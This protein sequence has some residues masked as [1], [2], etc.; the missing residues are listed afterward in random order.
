M[1][2][3]L[4]FRT[5]THMYSTYLLLCAAVQCNAMSVRTY[6][7]VTICRRARA[8]VVYDV[9][10][11]AAWEGGTASLRRPR[12]ACIH[13]RHMDAFVIATYTCTLCYYIE[14]N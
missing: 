10:Q 11:R 9:V 4:S 12:H 1:V 14:L 2:H 8:H 6:V 5:R 13:P 7:R 3:A